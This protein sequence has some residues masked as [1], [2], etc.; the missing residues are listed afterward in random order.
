MANG[1]L[2]AE[3]DN[4]Q[5]YADDHDQ[6]KQNFGAGEALVFCPEGIFLVFFIHRTTKIRK[7]NYLPGAESASVMMEPQREKYL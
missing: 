4:A 1:Q 6:V 3:N 7:F 2:F 5:D